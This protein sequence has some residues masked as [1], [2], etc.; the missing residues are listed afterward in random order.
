[1]C[2]KISKTAVHR[3]MLTAYLKKR[4]TFQE[5]M[6][7]LS[8]PSKK[9]IDIDFAVH[10]LCYRRPRATFEA[11]KSLRQFY[12]DVKVHLISDGGD[13]FSPIANYFHCD[14]TYERRNINSPERRR[15]Y[16]GIKRIHRTCEKYSSEWVILMEDDVRVRDRISKYPDAHIAGPSGPRF[17]AAIEKYL[18]NKYSGL[19]INGYNGC[20]GCIFNRLAFLEAYANITEIKKLPVSWDHRIHRNADALLTFTFLNAGFVARRWLDHS[21]ECGVHHGPASAFDHQFKFY[22]N[23]QMLRLKP[24]VFRPAWM[25]S[26]QSR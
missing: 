24:G 22:Y 5:Y 14:Y 17:T 1:V 9:Y 21:E 3:R 8:N 15:P 11:L 2:L 13:D 16:E 20:G 6:S 4:Q 19:E 12:P 23:H 7:D 18:R 26:V 25:S 10:F